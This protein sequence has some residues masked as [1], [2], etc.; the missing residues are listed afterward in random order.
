[1]KKIFILKNVYFET[2][3]EACTE[4]RALEVLAGVEPILECQK[5]F[6]KR[7]ITELFEEYVAGN[8]ISAVVKSKDGLFWKFHQIVLESMCSAWNC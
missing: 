8:D 5:P 6:W 4:E 1:M 3:S 7:R 2:E